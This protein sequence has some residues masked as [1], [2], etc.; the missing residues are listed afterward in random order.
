[1]DVFGIPRKSPW[2][3]Q[4]PSE[5]KFMNMCSIKLSV[6]RICTASVDGGDLGNDTKNH[7]N[8]K[9]TTKNDLSDHLVANGAT[10]S[11][12]TLETPQK[13]AKPNCQSFWGESLPTSACPTNWSKTAGG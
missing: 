12:T 8:R 11:K 13:H 9:Y 2:N 3:V 5:I 6:D 1:M 10:W 4:K 7:S